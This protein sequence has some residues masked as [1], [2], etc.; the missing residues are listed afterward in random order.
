MI[1]R[2]RR[3][4]VAGIV[5]VAI[6][7]AFIIFTVRRLRATG[8]RD[9]EDRIWF[10]L[11]TAPWSDTH[12]EKLLRHTPRSPVL[13]RQYVANALDRKDLP[14]AQRR[15]DMFAARAPRAPQAWISRAEVLR[16]CGRHDEAAA[17][18]RKAVRRHPRQPEILAA[19]AYEA[20]RREDWPE[21]A[22]RFEL[23]RRHAPT[24][25]DGYD[26]AAGVLFSDGR[27]D[28]AEAVLAE[29]MRRLPDEWT[30]WRAAAQL[31]GRAGD[32][33]EAAR[34][35]A[36]LRARFPLT[37]AGY[38]GGAE[39]LERSGDSAAAATLI[40]QA[41]DFFPGDKDV[42]KAAARQAGAEA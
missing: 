27:R 41:C 20:V 15:A 17:L 2:R 4:L 33:A 40:R 23:V 6:W 35:W 10:E 8:M 30:I 34:R 22:R 14:E 18:L 7:T 11:Q 21:A 24:R 36:A 5:A 26:V 3:V 28:E 13:L 38:L 29:G 37:A 31:A 19:L 25:V 16:A 32:H 42:A 9:V 1:P 39:A 12:V